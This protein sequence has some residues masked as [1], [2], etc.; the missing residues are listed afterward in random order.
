MANGQPRAAWLIGSVARDNLRSSSTRPR[1]TKS[2]GLE[3]RIDGRD[4][5]VEPIDGI[6]LE[7]MNVIERSLDQCFS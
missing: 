6:H 5:S 1:V 3:E 2:F 7:A 4:A